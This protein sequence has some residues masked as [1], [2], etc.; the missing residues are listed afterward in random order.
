MAEK[1][2]E[3]DVNSYSVDVERA[4]GDQVNSNH[5]PTAF[6]F[7]GTLSRTL[8]RW[9]TFRPSH[10]FKWGESERRYRGLALQDGFPR[11]AAWIAADPNKTSA[12]YKRFEALSARNLLHLQGRLAALEAHQIRFDLEDRG[13][14]D[15]DTISASKSWE[16]YAVLYP[17]ERPQ[18]VPE[19]V[20]DEW[21]IDYKWRRLVLEEGG[22]DVGNPRNTEEKAQRWELA[23]AIQNSLKEYRMDLISSL[24]TD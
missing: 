13:K 14:Q 6:L 2:R 4:Q 15:L 3:M 16:D 8:S 9:Q 22:I 21:E 1:P 20:Y 23:K 12:I 17:K 5:K 10:W 11:T 7:W 18:E 19:F 24:E